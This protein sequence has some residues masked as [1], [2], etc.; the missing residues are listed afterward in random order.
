MRIGRA[1]AIALGVLVV[2]AIPTAATA[3]EQTVEVTVLPA[4]TLSISVEEEVGLGVIVPGQ[5]TGLYEFG[6]EITNTTGSGWEVTVT[7]TDLTSFSWDCDEFGENCTRQPTD[8][9]YTIGAS[10][11]YVRG[12][13][14]NNWEGGDTAIVAYDGYLAAAGSP[15]TLMEGTSIASGR[16][17]LDEQRPGVALNIPSTVGETEPGEFADYYGILTYTITGTP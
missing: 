8:P 6:M 9:L 5:E 7:G 11:F 15:F 16:F 14:Q 12:G 13:D 17:G 2:L 3:A 10:A 1:R 4:D